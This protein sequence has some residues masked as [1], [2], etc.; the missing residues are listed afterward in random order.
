MCRSR[1][2]GI[3]GNLLLGMQRRPEALE[4]YETALGYMGERMGLL[5]N[6]A[7]LQAEMGRWE[8]A[9]ERAER[10]LAVAPETVSAWIVVGRVKVETGRF[11]E[12][13][14]AL[15]RA[16]QLAPHHPVLATARQR[17]DTLRSGG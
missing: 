1:N 10:A 4:A 8:Q 17:L 14:A 12:A 6:A 15:D 11:D 13:Q 16:A 5:T 2:P 9:V 7:V 3:L